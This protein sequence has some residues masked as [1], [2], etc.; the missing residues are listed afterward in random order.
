MK[1]V[2]GKAL[3]GASKKS[4]HTH[5]VVMTTKSKSKGGKKNAVK[6]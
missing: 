4:K 2:V 5:P 6:Y 1:K 3:A